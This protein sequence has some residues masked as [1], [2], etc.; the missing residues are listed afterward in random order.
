MYGRAEGY[1]DYR[2]NLIPFYEIRRF[3]HSAMNNGSI[4][5]IDIVINLMGNVLAFI[6]FGAL[7]RW[8]RNQKTGFWIAVL[9]TFL[10]SLF[11]EII[12]L[13]TRV[14]VFDVD[15]LILNTCGGAVGYGIYR[16]LRAIDRKRYKDG[17]KKSEAI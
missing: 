14:G 7:I 3:I 8:V 11:I 16:I 9:Y 10:F 5:G 4:R 15:D 12:Q 17:K 13:V 6:P 1:V 2:Y